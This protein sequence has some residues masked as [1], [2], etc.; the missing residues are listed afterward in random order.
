MNVAP[1]ELL[2]ES[3]VVLSLEMS[4]GEV[5][6]QGLLPEPRRRRGVERDEK[7]ATREDLVS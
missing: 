1:I 4:G 3:A 5:V 6:V 2:P 7:T